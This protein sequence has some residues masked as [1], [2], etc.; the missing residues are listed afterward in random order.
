[1]KKLLIILM[2]IT[3][4]SCCDDSCSDSRTEIRFAPVGANLIKDYCS[5]NYKKCDYKRWAKWEFEGECFLSYN[6]SGENAKLT[7]VNCE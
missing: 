2:L 7:K 3:L 5:E 1:M 6:L 4:V